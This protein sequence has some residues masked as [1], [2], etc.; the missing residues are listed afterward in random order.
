MKQ[1]YYQG[2]VDSILAIDR[3]DDFIVVLAELI[4]KLVVDHLHI[5]GEIY[6]R[7]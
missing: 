6:E 3:T 4:R 1:G 2:I 7:G 5:V